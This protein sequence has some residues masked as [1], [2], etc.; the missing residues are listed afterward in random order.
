MRPS[1]A[2]PEYNAEPICATDDDD[3]AGLPAGAGVDMIREL[4]EPN[5]RV[6][7]FTLFPFSHF[8]PYLVLLCSLALPIVVVSSR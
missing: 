2:E 4:S 5:F 7:F 3:A 8:L 6:H 1:V